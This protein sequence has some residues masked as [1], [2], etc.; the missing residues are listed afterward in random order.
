MREGGNSQEFGQLVEYR[1]RE[2]F[3]QGM[4]YGRNSGN[5]LTVFSIVTI[6]DC[7]RLKSSLQSKGYHEVSIFVACKPS[8][9]PDRPVERL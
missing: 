7:P 6:I 9:P 8:E 3:S 5:A 4:L 2:N 1:A